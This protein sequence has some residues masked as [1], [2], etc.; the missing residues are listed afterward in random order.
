MYVARNLKD[1]HRKPFLE[2]FGLRTPLFT[3]LEITE[4]TKE[5]IFKNSRKH[6]NT[7]SHVPIANMW[8]LENST[9]YM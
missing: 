4:D 8:Y 2:L 1:E 3:F 7:H 6:K 5:L 9:I